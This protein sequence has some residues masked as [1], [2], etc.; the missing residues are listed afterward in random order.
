MI[1]SAIVAMVMMFGLMGG[2]AMA[3]TKPIVIT[4]PAVSVHQHDDY[5]GTD[6]NPSGETPGCVSYGE[7]YNSVRSTQN[8]WERY[9][10]VSGMGEV[11]EWRDGG[12][13]I[14]RQYNMCK[15]SVK[16]D[17]V[18]VRYTRNKDGRYMTYSWSW[19]VGVRA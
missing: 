12:D 14:I 3:D 13:L 15:H 6:A 7:W 10:G 4:D 18:Q 9:A 2:T 1:R 17:S 19:M 5:A 11:I 8:A 16:T